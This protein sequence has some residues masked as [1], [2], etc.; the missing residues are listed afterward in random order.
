MFRVTRAA[1]SRSVFA[2]T[3]VLLVVMVA[4]TGA[5]VW[6]AAEVRKEQRAIREIVKGGVAEDIQRLGTLPGE[7]R[8]QFV[9]TVLV[10]LVLIV[11][12]IVLVFVVRAYLRNLRSLRETKM[13]ARDILASMDQGVIT[14]DRE[15]KIT[16][17]NPRGQE[18]L[19]VEFDC[20]GCPLDNI[21]PNGRPLAEASQDVLNSGKAQY[22][23]DFS[24]TRNSHPIQLRAECHVLRGADD[25]IGGTVLHIRDVTERMLVEERMRRMERFLGLGT[26]AAGLHHEIKNPL[27]ALSLHVQLLEER[28][29]GQADDETAETL[30]V[31]K[32]EVTR[33]AG[34]LESFRDYASIDRL[35]RANIDIPA[36][37]RQTVELIR[38]KAEQQ[39][40]QVELRIPETKVPPVPADATRLEQVFLN[41]VMNALDEMRAGGKLSLQPSLR[42]MEKPRSKFPTRVA[43]FPITSERE[44]LTLISR[45]KVTVRAWDLPYAI[46]SSASTEDKWTSIP[47]APAPRS[48]FH[49]LWTITD[50]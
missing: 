49:F 46:R 24:V 25:D 9:F 16:S 20:V 14:T 5:T 43:E 37:V 1:D 48:V 28:L 2:T 15:G 47:A 31:L 38:P 27:S 8:W 36:L 33:I 40:V 32:T 6:L 35:N 12:G 7:L 22:D 39:G 41:L 30:S 18:L 50:G 23:R 11:A 10:L 26:L 3:V 44:S 19:S 21:C 42:R 29:E 13:L 34:V 17:V 4:A 45:P